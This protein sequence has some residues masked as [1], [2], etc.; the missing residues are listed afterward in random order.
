MLLGRGGR[1]VEGG[2]GIVVVSHRHEAEFYHNYFLSI[3]LQRKRGREYGKGLKG[4][5]KYKNITQQ[6][7]SLEKQIQYMEINV[8]IAYY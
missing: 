2:I 4:H 1:V 7:L 5:Y 8:I 3:P 6:L